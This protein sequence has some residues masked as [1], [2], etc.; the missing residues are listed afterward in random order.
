MAGMTRQEQNFFPFFTLYLYC[1][2]SLN[3]G[4]QIYYK[5]SFEC[6]D[7]GLFYSETNMIYKSRNEGYL[8]LLVFQKKSRKHKEGKKCNTEKRPILKIY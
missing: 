3:F 1:P 7:L 4:R 6:E 2:L 5:N 8:F